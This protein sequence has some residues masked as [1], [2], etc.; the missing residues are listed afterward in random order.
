MGGGN[1]SKYYVVAEAS[2]TSF[3]NA[4]FLFTDKIFFFF[5]FIIQSFK[6]AYCLRHINHF[7]Q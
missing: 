6:F 7:L 5:I 4:N 1:Y 3:N 2:T